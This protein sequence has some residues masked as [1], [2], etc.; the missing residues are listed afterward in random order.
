MTWIL[1]VASLI[2]VVLNIKKNKFCFVIW[3]FTNFAW[4]IIDFYKNI[5][6]QGVLFLIYAG[7][8]I[9]GLVEWRRKA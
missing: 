8:A 6:A 5:P 2:G 4:A 3:L 7:L 1:V 9:W